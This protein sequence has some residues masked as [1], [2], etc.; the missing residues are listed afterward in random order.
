MK[1]WFKKYFVPHEEN[2]HKPHALLR[3]NLRYIVAI[4]LILELLLFVAPAVLIQTGSSGFLASV[5]PAVLS[6]LTNQNR[7]DNNVAPLTENPLLDQAATLK[8]QDMAAKGYF[9]HVSPVDGKTPWYWFDLV[10]YQYDAA[11]EN[12]AINFSDSQAVDTAWM[13]SPTHRA[14]ILKGEYTQFGTGIASGTYEGHQTIFIAQ[15]FARPHASAGGTGSGNASGTSVAIAS[16][17]P[18]AIPK[19]LGAETET[20]NISIMTPENLGP[21][22]PAFVAAAT[23]RHVSISFN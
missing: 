16:G 22:Y 2:G 10:G 18:S 17:T 4:V 9:S 8:A 15:D 19:V 13:N 11:G 14:N 23:F 7:I 12:L 1:K 5:L 6:S 21:F 3:E 20:P